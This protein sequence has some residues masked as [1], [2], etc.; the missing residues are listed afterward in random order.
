VDTFLVYLF[1]VRALRLAD[2]ASMEIKKQCI[3]TPIT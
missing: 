2:Q 3:R 1:L